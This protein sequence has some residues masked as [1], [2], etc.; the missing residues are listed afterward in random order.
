[1]QVDEL[2]RIWNEEFLPS[3]RQEIK[4]EMQSL[5]ANIVLRTE[6][7]NTLEKSQ[8]FISN[9]YDT[10][11]Q[12]LQNVKEQATKLD[13]RYKEAIGLLKAKQTKMADMAD[14]TAE[15]LYRIKCSLDETQQYLRRDCLEITGVPKT[16]H[17]N[18]IQLVKEIGTLIG[19]EIDDSHIAAA[20]RL[21][22]SKN[23]KN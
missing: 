10:I 8:Q 21:P 12:T 15:S 9:K 16:S 6:K 11:V 18:P 20:H 17:D 5:K 1:M 23:V 19:A 13:K 7:C 2:R 4:M 14:K 22:D 3:I